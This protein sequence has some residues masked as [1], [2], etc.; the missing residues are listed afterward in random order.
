LVDKDRGLGGAV[1]DG[2][3]RM[4]SSITGVES[5]DEGVELAVGGCRIQ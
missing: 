3:A 2:D 4:T 5:M 1:G